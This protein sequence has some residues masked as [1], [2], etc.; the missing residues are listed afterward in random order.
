MAT[1]QIRRSIL[2]KPSWK[3]FF[4]VLTTFGI[5]IALASRSKAEEVASSSAS[6]KIPMRFPFHLDSI[7]S[8]KDFILITKKSNPEAIVRLT[9]PSKS[10]AK[11]SEIERDSEGDDYFI[12]AASPVL[13]QIRFRSFEPRSKMDTVFADR[14]LTEVNLWQEI[15]GKEDMC[16]AVLST[17]KDALAFVQ[18]TYSYRTEETGDVWHVSGC[19]SV[20]PN[21]IQPMALPSVKWTSSDGTYS[22]NLSKPFCFCG[23]GEGFCG[24]NKTATVC[25]ISLAY[26]LNNPN[27]SMRVM[28]GYRKQFQEQQKRDDA[29]Y[30]KTKANL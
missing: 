23:D 4:S 26:D 10:S 17:Y 13:A 22:I 21:G 25:H 8:L 2:S 16:N 5:L 18:T 6:E 28:N 19:L 1:G 7:L 9:E 29:E 3:H 15:K 24:E 11:R 14:Q 30:Q 27:Y 20:G 12:T